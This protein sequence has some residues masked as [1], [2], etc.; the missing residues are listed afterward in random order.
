RR[1]GG[2]PLLRAGYAGHAGV[3]AVPGAGLHGPRRAP[4]HHRCLRGLED[5]LRPATP[6]APYAPR[7]LG[8][9]V[10]R[11]ASPSRFDPNTARLIVMPGKRTSQGAFRAYSAA[12]T[13]SMRPQDG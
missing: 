13:E 12:D 6:A 5:F 2:D 1:R 3:G 4:A 8:S 7:S 10:S 9:R 11:S